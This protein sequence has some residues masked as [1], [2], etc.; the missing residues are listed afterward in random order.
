MKEEVSIQY[1]PA[2]SAIAGQMTLQVLSEYVQ[3]EIAEH[4]MS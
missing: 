2:D 4:E 1:L 3:H